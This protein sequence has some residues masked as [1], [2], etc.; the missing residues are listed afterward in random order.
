MNMYLMIIE[1]ELNLIFL[2]ISSFVVQCIVTV[3]ETQYLNVAVLTPKKVKECI[4][5][6]CLLIS[7]TQMKLLYFLEKTVSKN[8]SQSYIYPK[9]K[10]EIV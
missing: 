9:H 10:R 3:F 8:V 6:I 5:M 2:Y 1:Q 7:N 4:G